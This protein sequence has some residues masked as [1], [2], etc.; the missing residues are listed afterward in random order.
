MLN[1]STPLFQNLQEK[2]QSYH[3]KHSDTPVLSVNSKNVF[4]LS[5]FKS[6]KQ[7]LQPITSFK[8][9]LK[10]SHFLQLIM[11]LLFLLNWFSI[12]VYQYLLYLSLV[13]CILTKWKQTLIYH[14]QII[15]S[16]DQ[17]YGSLQ[18]FLLAPAKFQIHTFLSDEIY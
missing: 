7:N 10:K 1:K 17:T 6:R 11:Q 9:A 3:I 4:A 2:T 14:L 12:S 15:Q 8:N 18:S 16:V 5:G 13:L